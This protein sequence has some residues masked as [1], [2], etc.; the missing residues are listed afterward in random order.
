MY[1]IQEGFTLLMHAAS[2]GR[3]NAIKYLLQQSDI[4]IYAKDKVKA[5]DAYSVIHIHN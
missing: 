1:R 5:I 3:V 4:D 2:F